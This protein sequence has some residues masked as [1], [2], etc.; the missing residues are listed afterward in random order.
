MKRVI[1]RLRYFCFIRVSGKLV[2]MG[3]YYTESDAL[4]AANNIKDADGESLIRQFR[5]VDIRTAKAMMR[6]EL[7]QKTGML[8][9]TLKPIKTGKM[10]KEQDYLK[11]MQ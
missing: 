1:N 8:G 4:N 3:P 11:D 6:A 10:E 9:E 7:S 5:T 2:A